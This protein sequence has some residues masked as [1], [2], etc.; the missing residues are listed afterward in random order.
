MDF[1][2]ELDY[3][4]KRYY[5]TELKDLFIRENESFKYDKF[6][7]TQKFNKWVSM[8]CDHFGLLLEKKQDN[9]GRFI[10]ISKIPF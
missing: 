1:M 8:Y 3:A 10:E 9:K 7:N 5:K 4:G 2:E 6:F